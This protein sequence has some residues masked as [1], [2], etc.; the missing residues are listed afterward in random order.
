MRGPL[1]DDGHVQASQLWPTTSGP[2]SIPAVVQR[3]LYA[4]APF[5]QPALAQRRASV[6]C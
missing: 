1:T 2:S 5:C 6:A 3:W 4:M